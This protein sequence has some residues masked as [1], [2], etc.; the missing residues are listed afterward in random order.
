MTKTGFLHGSTYIALMG[1]RPAAEGAQ[2]WYLNGQLHRLDG[3]ATIW[4]DGG[5][6]WWVNGQRH[7]EDGPAV[8]DADGGLEWY[9]NGEY[10]K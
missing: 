2:M 4:A 10:I 8:I 9:I 6:E 3:P 5:L 1:Q 7:R